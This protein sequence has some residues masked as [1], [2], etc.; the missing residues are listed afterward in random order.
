MARR[1]DDHAVRLRAHEFDC[2]VFEV[3]RGDPETHIGC[4]ATQ[5][6]RQR[7][8]GAATHEPLVLEMN[9]ATTIARFATRQRPA[10]SREA[11]QRAEHE[12]DH[13]RNAD[14]LRAPLLALEAEYPRRFA[15]FSSSSGRAAVPP[16]LEGTEN[17]DQHAEPL[18]ATTSGHCARPQATPVAAASHTE[19]AVVR[20]FTLSSACPRMMEPAPRNPTPVMMPWMT[21]EVASRLAVPETPS[22]AEHEHR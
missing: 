9:C 18:A 14:A 20:P 4:T 22:G 3:Q 15:A 12:E 2:A 8:C 11:E 6:K 10:P 1:L 5:V 21:R 16:S 13:Q 17:E 7:R 19:A